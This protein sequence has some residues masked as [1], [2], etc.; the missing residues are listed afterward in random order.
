MNNVG[1]KYVYYAPSQMENADK[2]RTLLGRFWHHDA[3]N[4][5]LRYG[6]KYN[7]KTKKKIER[8]MKNYVDGLYDRER[9]LVGDLPMRD[10]RIARVRFRAAMLDLSLIHI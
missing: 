6:F 7:A 4:N 9:A 1:Q 2:L 5:Q 3:E 8:T 10:A